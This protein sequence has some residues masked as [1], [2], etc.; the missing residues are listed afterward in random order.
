M[1][2]IDIKVKNVKFFEKEYKLI[3]GF[4]MFFCVILKGFKYW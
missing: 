1:L 3:D 2:L 4:G